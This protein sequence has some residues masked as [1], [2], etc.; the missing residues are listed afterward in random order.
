MEMIIMEVVDVGE[1]GSMMKMI[2]E[3]GCPI[4]HHVCFGYH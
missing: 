3:T 4:G 2:I 1:C